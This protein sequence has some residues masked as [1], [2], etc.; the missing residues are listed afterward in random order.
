[1]LVSWA[2]PP[3]PIKVV[4]AYK[5]DLIMSMIKERLCREIERF[6][7]RYGDMVEGSIIDGYVLS[8]CLSKYWDD[9]CRMF[10]DKMN[11]VRVG[12][13]SKKGENSE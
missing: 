7:E 9:I 12:Y 6:Y 4:N 2:M 11:Y 1:M 13:Y 3:K 8:D 10:Q 5:F